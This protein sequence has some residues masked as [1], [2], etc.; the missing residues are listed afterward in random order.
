ME[1]YKFRTHKQKE[2]QSLDEFVTELRKLAKTCEFTN[3]DKEILSQ[4]IQN[5]K[6]NRLRRRALR[7]PDKTLNDILTLGR[8]LEMADTQATEMERETTVNKITNTNKTYPKTNYKQQR[9]QQA[10][11]SYHNPNYSNRPTR[12]T[13]CRNCGGQFPHKNGPCPANGKT[14]NACHKQNHFAKV[15]RGKSKQ[16]KYTRDRRV[17]EIQTETSQR[18]SYQASL[19][20]SDEEYSY[21]IKEAVCSIK[22]SPFT[23]IKVNNTTCSMM[24]DT[25]AT[26]NIL[27]DK[28]HKNIGSPKLNKNDIKLLPY[29]G[30]K[31]LE[32]TGACELG[33]ETKHKYGVHKF[34]VVRGGHG[35]LIGYPTAS[36]LGL[37]KIIQPISIQAPEKRYPDV[38]RDEIGKYTGGSVKLH[39]DTDIR[40]VAQRNRKTAF[41]IRPKVEKEIQKLL[42]QDIIEKI[43]NTPTPWVSPIVTP[44]KKNPE[45]IRL[46]VD[47]REANKAIIRERHLLPTVEEL[48][49][50]LNHASVF[51]KLDLRAGYHQLELQEPSRYITTFSTH[52][53]LFRYK[54]LNFG[55]SSASEIFQETI[56]CVIQNVQNAK[57]I[58]D[59]II[60]YGKSQEEHDEALNDTLQALQ[61]NGLTVN[62]AKCEFNKSKVTFFGVVFSKEGISPDPS[63][64]KAVKD[65]TPPTTVPELRSFLGMTNY[66]SRFIRNYAS[67]CEPLR[68]L[69]RHTTWTGNG[70]LSN[71]THLTIL[72]LSYLVR[73]PVGLGAII[74]QNQKTIAYA[75]RAL[76]DV[77][78]RYSQT[79]REALAIVWACEHFDI[80]IRGAKNVNIITDHKPLERIWQKAKIPLRIERWGLR[81]QPYKLTIK[82]QPG[83]D[84]PADYMSR[85][86]IAMCSKTRSHEEKVAEQYVNFIANQAIPKAMSLSEVKGASLTD[87]TLQKAIELTRN[88]K[89]YELKKLDDPNLDIQELQVY[90]SIQDEL[91]VH[92]EN[93]LLRDNRIVMPM[94]LRD[95]AVSLAHEGHQGLTKT[96][97]FIRSKV[98]FPGIN[99][100]V[101]SLIK[102]CIACQALTRSKLMEPLKMSEMPGRTMDCTKRRF[103][104]STTVWRLPICDNR[105]I[106]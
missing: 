74:S 35:A 18:E 44:P 46:C 45:E 2:G 60:I 22:K 56:R 55:I 28:T 31:P 7:E 73:H 11:S 76:T 30:G 43:G 66:S 85:H 97:A 106:F 48:I 69:T 96:K 71:K 14:C 58:S 36:Q 27:D 103:L 89:W 92:D 52:M 33:V 32:V 57:N 101:D 38:F 62:K 13:Q 80:F 86:P 6:S 78:S 70:L 64:V 42:D 88:G 41:H 87:R 20:S 94:S 19:D 17:H 15:C 26:V 10:S 4:V 1:V 5:C 24:I 82:Y 77:E 99:D 25:G 37:V 34:Y 23:M 49:H 51:S 91:V 50:D 59:D 65:A 16:N 84:N 61:R 95:R 3:V 12:Q 39:I 75:S 93:I 105:R 100:R 21:S 102:D 83:R 68:R 40:P 90:R 8:T 63:K 81:L 72:K 79:E 47:M 29:G 54:R 9:G 53:G 98:W 104:W 67:I